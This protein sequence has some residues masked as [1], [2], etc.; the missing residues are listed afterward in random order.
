MLQTKIYQDRTQILNPDGSRSFRIISDVLEPGELPHIFLF[1]W[2]ILSEADPTHD[3]F[4]RVGSPYD[5]QH[6]YTDRVAAV[7]AHA[8]Y[9]LSAECRNF[10]TDLS[11]ALQAKDALTTRINET[12]NTWYSYKTQFSG[13]GDVYYPTA[14]PAYEQA[15]KDAYAAAKAARI[16][17]E[18]AVVASTASLVNA[19]SAATAAQNIVDIYKAEVEFCTQANLIDWVGYHDA[20]DTFL[21]AVHVATTGLIARYKTAYFDWSGLNYPTNTGTMPQQ[22]FCAA[23]TDL[24][25]GDAT[26]IAPPVATYETDLQNQFDTFC[27]NANSHYSSS[28]AQKTAKD[29]A[30]ADAQ[31]AKEKAEA[32]LTNAQ[33]NEDAALANVRNV[34]PDFDPSSV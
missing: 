22:S 26:M 29:K 12:I 32:S 10:Y 30:V 18:D 1:V 7:A 6:L 19:Q 33:A 17:A 25:N 13:S 9:Y 28:I 5:I 16:S 3:K 15:L 31:I 14:D 4:T 21:S 27:A 20:V 2:E 11:V 23:I 24:I 8:Q 34:C